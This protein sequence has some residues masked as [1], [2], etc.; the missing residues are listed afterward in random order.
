MTGVSI[1]LQMS[2][3][4]TYSQELET[5]KYEY[6][7]THI[8]NQVCVDNVKQEAIKMLTIVITS[9]KYNLK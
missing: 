4:K 6:L 7:E 3:I 9:S 5:K 8:L 2:A 1:G